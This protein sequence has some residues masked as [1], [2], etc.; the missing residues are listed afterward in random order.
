MERDSRT[1][2]SSERTAVLATLRRNPVLFV[3]VL[4]W[5]L[6]QVPG[7]LLLEVDPLLASAFSPWRSLL[8]V[9][10]TPFVHAG[11]IGMADEALDG[12]AS[13]RTFVRTGRDHYVSVLPAYLVVAA[14]SAVL[15]LGVLLGVAF[16]FL[17][18]SGATTPVPLV[19]G[20]VV[21]LALVGC[22]LALTF[23]QFY[24][25]AI[26]IDEAGF[27]EGFER[28][29]TL[30]RRH[31]LRTLGYSALGSITAAIFAVGL[32]LWYLW[33]SAWDLTGVGLALPELSPPE[34]AGGTAVLLGVQTLAG[35]TFATYSVAFYRAI[36]D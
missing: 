19:I 1:A 36:S 17:F 33:L 14:V 2:I 8:L 20:G 16:L 29:A 5:T 12:S 15:G 11:L 24:G 7:S 25:H 18:G 23:V 35:G 21:V 6:V 13:L 31:L 28:S 3:P 32:V 10:V 34:I 30:V 9:T 27:V 4:A 26:V 22:L